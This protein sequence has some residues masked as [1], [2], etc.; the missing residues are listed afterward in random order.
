[1]N[2]R[3]ERAKALLVSDACALTEV[4]AETGFS[5]QAHFT[6]VFRKHVGTTPAR[7]RK[8]RQE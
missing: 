1:M 5:D 8:A 2:A 3:L 7:W 6:K 4:A